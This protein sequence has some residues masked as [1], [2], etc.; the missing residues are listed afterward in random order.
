MYRSDLAPDDGAYAQSKMYFG[1]GPYNGEAI[2]TDDIEITLTSSPIDGRGGI[3]SEF[4]PDQRCGYLRHHDGLGVSLFTD[5][6]LMAR[7]V[8]LFVAGIMPIGI[9]ISPVLDRGL[10]YEDGRTIWKD[11]KIKAIPIDSYHFIYSRT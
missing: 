10:V 3:L 1:F 7:F 11:S 9:K 8:D 5:D 2:P 4:P 6:N